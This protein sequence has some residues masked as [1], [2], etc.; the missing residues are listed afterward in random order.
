[1]QLFNPSNVVIQTLTSATGSFSV[2]ATPDGT[3]RARC[4]VDGSITSP[5]CE[6]TIQNN[7]PASNP[8]CNALT[9]APSVIQG[10]TNVAYYCD[11]TDATSY[12][13]QLFNPSNVVIQTLTNSSG[14]FSVPGTP[15]GI[16]RARCTI[17]GSITSP[18]CEKTIQNDPDTP[19]ATCNAL[20]ATPTTITGQT[21]VYFSCNATNATSYYIE[22]RNP[23]NTIIGNIFSPTGSIV[24]PATPDGTYTARCTVDNTITNNNCTTTITN[25]AQQQPEIEVIK[26]DQDT[27]HNDYQLVQIGGNALFTVT[28][29]NIGQESINNITL[30][31]TLTPECNRSSIQTQSIMTAAGLGTTLDPGESFEYTCQKNNISNTTFPQNTNTVCVTGFGSSSGIQ[32]TDC[33]DTYITPSQTDPAIQI[34]KDDSDNHDDR[35]YIAQYETATFDITVY[36]IG[37]EKLENVA[38]SDQYAANCVRSDSSTRNLI[39]NIGNDD[40][41]LDP[42]ESF[43]YTCS[44]SNVSNATFPNNQNTACV[45]ARGYRSNKSVSDCDPTYVFTSDPQPAINIIKDDADNYDDTQNLVTGGRAR[46]TIIVENTGD[47]V[48]ENVSID[49]PRAPDCDRT[50]SQTRSLFPGSTFDPGEKFTYQ[51]DRS[52]VR[53]SMFPN[54]ENVACVQAR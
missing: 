36:N 28:V 42:G 5:A 20:T 44:R 29:R 24:L 14:S 27:P 7:P 17:N 3:Y 37:D 40:T 15:D 10:T 31:D 48:L 13:L 22:L 1:M 49:D 33:D 2:P 50:S 45:Q 52:N 26:D 23:N 9:I 21:S 18:S 16:Y 30:S 43:T 34:I 12:T 41:F 6:K 25:N 51:C 39:D 53:S 46:F 38:I 32:D 35:Q 8:T 47:E 4:T 54:D 19:P 11:A